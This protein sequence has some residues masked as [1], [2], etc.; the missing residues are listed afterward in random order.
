[1][2]KTSHRKHELREKSKQQLNNKNLHQ[3]YEAGLWGDV[4]ILFL[5]IGLGLFFVMPFYSL[6]SGTGQIL[7]MSMYLSIIML[8]A[9]LVWHKKR[10]KR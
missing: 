2:S 1:M 8:F 10:R 3:D 5:I 4:L 7:I 9:I 6:L